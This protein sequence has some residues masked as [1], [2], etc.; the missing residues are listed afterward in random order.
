[1]KHIDRTEHF[2]RDFKGSEVLRE[3]L[4]TSGIRIWVREP[5]PDAGLFV[6]AGGLALLRR[7]RRRQ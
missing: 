4:A 1:M 7:R 6:A 3:A 2:R 5:E